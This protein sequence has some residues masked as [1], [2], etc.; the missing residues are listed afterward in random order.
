M[1]K[2]KSSLALLSIPQ[3]CDVLWSAMEGA[4]ESR[5]CGRCDTVVHDL[6]AMGSEHANR[7]LDSTTD[8]LCVRKQLTMSLRRPRPPTRRAALHALGGV[9]L[10]AGL[11]CTPARHS[12][13]KETPLSRALRDLPHGVISPEDAWEILRTAGWTEQEIWAEALAYRSRVSEPGFTPPPS[14]SEEQKLGVILSVIEEKIGREERD[15]RILNVEDDKIDLKGR[16]IGR[17]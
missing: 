6:D 10:A 9:F 2:P 15:M 11:G 5:V 16:F 1:T 4:D 3:P 13:N 7:L 12:K 8:R 17:R 14:G